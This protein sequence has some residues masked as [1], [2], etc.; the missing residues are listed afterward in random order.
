GDDADTGPGLRRPERVTGLVVV[1]LASH[2]DGARLQVDVCRSERGELGPAE[3]SKG[4]SH[5]GAPAAARPAAPPVRR[6]DANSPPAGR[7]PG[8]TGPWPSAAAPAAAALPSDV[9]A[10]QPPQL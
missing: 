6:L 4:P 10:S 7:S 8:A 3:A 2:P 1:E 5:R 9:A